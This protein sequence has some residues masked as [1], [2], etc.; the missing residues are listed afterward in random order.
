MKVSRKI[1]SG[2]VCGVNTGQS[3]VSYRLS[4]DSPASYW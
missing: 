2:F 3:H 4:R 1:E